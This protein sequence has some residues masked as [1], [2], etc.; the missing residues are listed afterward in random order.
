MEPGIGSPFCCNRS[1][2]EIAEEIRNAF[3]WHIPIPAV[4][5]ASVKDGNVILLGEAAWEYERQ[6]I[7]HVVRGLR[8]VVRVINLV[9]VK[10]PGR[11]P[12]ISVL[13][14]RDV[15]IS[16]DLVASLSFGCGNASRKER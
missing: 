9:A 11:Q 8:G 12:T 14:H 2:R 7:E 6:N 10:S 13:K 1:D 15:S 16:T 3:K 5:N 4:L